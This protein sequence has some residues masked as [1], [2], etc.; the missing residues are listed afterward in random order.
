MDSQPVSDHGRCV[1][2]TREYKGSLETRPR[3]RARRDAGKRAIN[4]SMT[5]RYTCSVLSVL[6]GKVAPVGL[7]IG[8]KIVI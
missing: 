1:A 3:Y 5:T 7:Q 4:R 2:S 8:A 6:A